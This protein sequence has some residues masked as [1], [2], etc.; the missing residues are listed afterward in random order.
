MRTSCR[1]E[2]AGF[3]SL[4]L[5]FLGASVGAAPP[6]RARARELGIRI[7]RGEA[8]GWNA[9]TDVAGVLVGQ[10]TIVRGEGKDAVRTGVTAV[11]PRKD[12]WEN[13]V[14]ASVFV[15]NGNGQ[16]TGQP[17]IEDSELLGFPILLTNTASVGTV[18]DAAN[19]YLFERYPERRSGLQTVVA[20]C[21]DGLLNDIRGM[22]VKAE[23][24]YAALEGA[25][26]GPVDEGAVGAGTG[27]VCY[28]FKGGVGTASRRVG[29]FTVGALVLTNHGSRE[30]LV[31]DGVPVGREITNLLPQVYEPPGRSSILMILATDAPMSSRQLHRLARRATLGLA[32]TG[33]TAHNSSGAIAI[34][35]STAQTVPFPGGDQIVAV[36]M[37]PL[38]RLDPLFDA[39]AEATEEA[40]V[41]SLTM[42]RTMTGLNGNT[43][44]ALPLDR[45]LDILSRYRRLPR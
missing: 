27:M 8:G 11:L 42:A 33:S 14:F 12:V 26:S 15:L 16:I 41:N 13:R 31:I 5:G 24:V 45:L 20:E 22:Q 23:H 21:W 43:V 28:G 40:I 3:L 19:R 29:D 17:W 9:I 18:Y 6:E 36:K 30:Q 32:R 35:F 25:K 7:G 10:A 39:A 37:L 44:H 1:R 2:V 4:L 38:A 34:A